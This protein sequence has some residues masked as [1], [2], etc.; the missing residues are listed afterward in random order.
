MDPCKLLEGRMSLTT[1]PLLLV[2]TPYHSP[3]GRSLFS[4]LLPAG[5]EGD[6]KIFVVRKAGDVESNCRSVL[7]LLCESVGRVVEVFAQ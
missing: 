3:R 6:E 7:I 5:G 2:V 4:C 1:I